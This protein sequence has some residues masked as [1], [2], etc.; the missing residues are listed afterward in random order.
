MRGAAALAAETRKVRREEESGDI[1][2]VQ[3]AVFPPSGARG[4]DSEGLVREVLALLR[5]ALGGRMDLDPDTDWRGARVLSHPVAT[6]VL[7][8]RI[9]RVPWGALKLRGAR[10]HL[11]AITTD[12][13]YLPLSAAVANPSKAG[14]EAAENLAT[15]LSRYRG[16]EDEPGEYVKRRRKKGKKRRVMTTDQ[17]RKVES[18][19]RAERRERAKARGNRKRKR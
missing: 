10:I 6:G 19:K 14:S 16:T 1:A 17:R 18:K 4:F 15:D 9:E 13:E 12:G 7:M 8:S 11:A 2:S 3:V 5:P